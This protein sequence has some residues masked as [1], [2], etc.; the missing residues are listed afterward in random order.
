MK[1]TKRTE[2]DLWMYANG[3]TDASFAEA[4]KA[5]LARLGEPTGGVSASSVHKWK[6]GENVPRAGKLKAIINVTDGDVT[7]GSI[8]YAKDAR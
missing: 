5:E 7:L 3:Y 6:T 2:L 4:I 8:L 1:R